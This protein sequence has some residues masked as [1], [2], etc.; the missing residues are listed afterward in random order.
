MRLSESAMAMYCV[1]ASSDFASSFNS[2]TALS[3]CADERV[4]PRIVGD[5]SRAQADECCAHLVDNL[6]RIALPQKEVTHGSHS[7][8]VPYRIPR[9]SHSHR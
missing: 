9:P 8:K 1:P 5:P 4:A 3:K 6:L 7:R 2:V